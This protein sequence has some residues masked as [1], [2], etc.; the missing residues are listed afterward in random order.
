V[1]AF[2][3]QASALLESVIRDVVP[4]SWP[5]TGLFPILDAGDEGSPSLCTA[6]PRLVL[7][8]WGR[9]M[10]LCCGDGAVLGIQELCPA[11]LERREL[12][13]WEGKFGAGDAGAMGRSV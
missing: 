6:F 12:W 3:S 8:R 10:W 4:F 5:Q 1:V 7:W 9:G 11:V 2:P 13:R